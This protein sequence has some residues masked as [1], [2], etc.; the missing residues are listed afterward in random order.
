MV[1]EAAAAVALRPPHPLTAPS[2]EADVAHSFVHISYR[3]GSGFCARFVE[4]D[5]TGLTLRRKRSS[6]ARSASYFLHCDCAYTNPVP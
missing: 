5:R 2:P 3:T 1:Q 4:D 6:P